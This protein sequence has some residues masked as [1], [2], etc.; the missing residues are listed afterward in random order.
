MFQ[1]KVGMQFPGRL[2]QLRFEEVKAAPTSPGSQLVK[3]LKSEIVSQGR[4]GAFVV[5]TIVD[6][7]KG[8]EAQKLQM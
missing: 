6:D 1:A 5:D 8:Y 4:T 2:V 7:G 3:M